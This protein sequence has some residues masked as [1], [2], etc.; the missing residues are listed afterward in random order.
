MTRGRPAPCYA[1]PVRR[2]PERYAEL[3]RVVAERDPELVAAVAEV[4]WTLLRWSLSLSPLER[5]RAASR[6][7]SALTRLRHVPAQR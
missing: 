6:A 7:A 2:T 3:E 5:L 1:P 4:D